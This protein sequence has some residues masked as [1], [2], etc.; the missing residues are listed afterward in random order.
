MSGDQDSPE[1]SIGDSV[2]D[3]ED[4]DPNEA[5][6]IRRSPEETIV[7]WEHE[8]DGETVTTA[9]E[10]PEYPEDEQ[11]VVVAFRESLESAWPD[12]Q[13][14]DPDALFEGAADRDVNRYGFPEGRLEPI[15]PGELDAEWLDGLGDRLADAG[16]EVER[17]PTELVVEQFDERY[18]IDADGEI[19]GDGQYQTPL[20]NLVE[21]YR[22]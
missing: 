18:R 4:D 20:S 14:A 11:L 15:E 2:I 12:W 13:E 21:N 17:E 16:W 6:V 8:S 22:S 19:A 10:N 1:L 5:V 7:D 9:D 3:R